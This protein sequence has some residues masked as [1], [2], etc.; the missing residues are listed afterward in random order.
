MKIFTNVLSYSLSIAFLILAVVLPGR[1]YSADLE[2]GANVIVS[3]ETTFTVNSISSG[4]TLVKTTITILNDNGKRRAKLYVPYD[5]LSKVD[6]IKGTSY[7]RFGKKIKTL[8]KSDIVDVSSINDFS[9]FEDNRVKIADLTHTSY[10]YVVEYEYQTTSNNMLFYPTWA[11]QDDD[12]LAVKDAS[13]KVLMPKGM[14]L[15]YQ[16]YNLQE[17]VKQESTPTH[18]V[19]VWKVN[20]LAAV[21]LEPYGPYFSEVIPMVR[22]APNDFEVQG[23][24][25][26]METWEAYGKWINKLNEGRGVLPEATKKK[27]QDMVAKAQ[28]PAEKVKI[29]YNYLQQ[30]T[31]Y[32]SIQLGIGGWQPFEASFVDAK[33]YGDCKALTNY[34]QSMLQA[35]GI[36]SH[37]ALIRAG[38]NIP[39]IQADFPSSQFNH[40]ILC[41]PMKADTLWL[42]CTSQ[43]ASAGYM[44]SSTGNRNALLITPTGGKIVKTPDYKA[45]DNLQKRSI[46]VSLDEKGNGLAR[47]T[48]LYA[49]EQQESYDG[50]MNHL[51]PEDQKKWL[52]NNIKMPSF[53]IASF[54]FNQ[55]KDRIPTV[56]EKLELNLRQCATLSGK[57][58]FVT[59]NLMNRWESAPRQVEKRQYEVVRG[60]SFFDIDTV[61]YQIPVGYTLEYQPQEVVHTSQFGEYKAKVQV[62][63]QKLVYIRSLQMHKGRYN[64]D[65]YPAMVEF[66]NN[67]VK[68]DGQQAVF[69]KN[70]N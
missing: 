41:V 15:R 56:T 53:E 14:N 44:G 9:L 57:R 29:V 25:G 2:K 28:D 16:E 37:H 17:K 61:E 7:D 32:I 40:V 39:N 59:L 24:R 1:A 46:A 5:K 54:A 67:I 13:F 66:I 11:P 50:M 36:E 23:Y 60:M 31:R 43:N 8:K 38:D 34:T 18:E 52:Y 45:P 58:M 42:E 63:G 33:G 70:I 55:T 27:L 4:T 19:Y 64:R 20:N 62:D 35:I 49:G 22:T 10:P 69:V 26:N 68:A 30:N 3:E 6:F 51:K 48:T 65:T 21:E 47:I 12:K